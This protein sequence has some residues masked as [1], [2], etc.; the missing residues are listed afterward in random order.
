M[1]AVGLEGFLKVGT[2]PHGPPLHAHVLAAYQPPRVPS[3]AT[4]IMMTFTCLC[5]AREG[6]LPGVGGRVGGKGGREGLWESQRNR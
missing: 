4:P 6:L 1:E 5:T 3:I 2:A